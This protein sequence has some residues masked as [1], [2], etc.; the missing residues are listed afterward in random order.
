MFSWWSQPWAVRTALLVGGCYLVALRAWASWYQRRAAPRDTT[1]VD[2][3]NRLAQLALIPLLLL[4]ALEALF[5]T[6]LGQ[7]PLGMLTLTPEVEGLLVLLGGIAGGAGLVVLSWAHQALGVHFSLEVQLKEGHRLVQRGPY[8]YVRNPIYSGA[9]LLT[10]GAAIMLRSPL[11]LVLCFPFG[12]GLQRMAAAEVVL[13]R[14]TF[15]AEY[16]SYLG[17]TG[18]FLPRL[19]RRPPTD[20][21]SHGPSLRRQG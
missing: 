1:R 21:P 3:V 7:L 11:L 4:I 13:L 10:F 5:P 2:G 20:G 9:L 8:R 17:R 15:G 16:Q 19:G 6:F 14:S 18:A 12:Y